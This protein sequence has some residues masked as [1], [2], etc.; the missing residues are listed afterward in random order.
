MPNFVDCCGDVPP[1]N[2]R[3]YGQARPK[4]AFHCLD[5]THWLF[6]QT[7]ISSEVSSRKRCETLSSYMLGFEGP[8][9]PVSLH[10]GCR[11]GSSK[12]INLIFF[13]SPTSNAF[14]SQFFACS[15]RP[16]W[17]S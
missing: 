4:K 15:N 5:A 3:H 7:N 13:G 16:N 10:N 14:P 9:S 2:N 12:A 17:H 1:D 8:I 6:T 11:S